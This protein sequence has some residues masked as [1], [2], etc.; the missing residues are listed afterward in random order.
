M[1]A[2]LVSDQQNN[3]LPMP[4]RDP[5]GDAPRSTVA[6]AEALIRSV[7]RVLHPNQDEPFVMTCGGLSRLRRKTA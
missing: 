2:Q 4:R 3:A 6:A 7:D 5:Q 1:K